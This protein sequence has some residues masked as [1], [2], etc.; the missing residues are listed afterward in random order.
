MGRAGRQGG[1]HGVCGAVPGQGRPPRTKNCASPVEGGMVREVGG[2]G[3]RR[4]RAWFRGGKGGG[5]GACFLGFR[6]VGGGAW[7]C[8]VVPGQGMECGDCWGG[9]YAQEDGIVCEASKGRRAVLN[10]QGGR[11]AALIQTLERMH[12]LKKGRQSALAWRSSSTTALSR[13][14]P[15]H[16]PPS[17]EP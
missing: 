3:R 2:G 16:G 13:G 11:A 14:S 9:A 7:V 10:K 5:G 8:W 1:E 12:T 6:G 15:G 4:W 17:F